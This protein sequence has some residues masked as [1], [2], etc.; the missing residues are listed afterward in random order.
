MFIV[1]G[2]G[3][4]GIE[5]IKKRVQLHHQKTGCYPVVFIDY[6]QIIKP[7]DPKSSDKQ[8]TDKAVFELK[9][10]SRDFDI[11]IIVISSLNR[12]NYY[13]PISME[14]FKESGAIEYSTDVLIGLQFMGLEEDGFTVDMAKRQPVRN[15]GVKILKN[16]N[17]QTGDYFHYAFI[18]RLNLFTEK[19]LTEEP[20]PQK[21][22]KKKKK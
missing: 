9:R 5:E 12:A 17:G 4:C 19:G 10:I 22:Q 13:T 1:E 20:K 21:P 15:V 6:L 11:P 18:P 7:L 2:V 8:N 16:R 3:D 14:A